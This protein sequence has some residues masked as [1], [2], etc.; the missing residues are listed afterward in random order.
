MSRELSEYQKALRKEREWEDRVKIYSRCSWC[1]EPLEGRGELC[2]RDQV[3]LGLRPRPKKIG[4]VRGPGRPRKRKFLFG[5]AERRIKA[6]IS[7]RA[8]L[9]RGSYGK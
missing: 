3:R 1:G 2:S 4:S 5:K 7:N 9:K 6:I 8:R